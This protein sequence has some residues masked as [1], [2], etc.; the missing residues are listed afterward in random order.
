MGKKRK[1]DLT[2]IDQL[3]GRVDLPDVAGVGF[4]NIEDGFN[5]PA[6]PLTVLLSEVD[7]GEFGQPERITVTV[8]PGDKL[9]LRNA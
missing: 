2:Q 9:R 8:R 6:R 3:L 1:N 7:W 4:T 5:P